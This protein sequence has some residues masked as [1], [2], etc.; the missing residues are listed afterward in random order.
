MMISEKFEIIRT[1]I[2]FG[3]VLA[4]TISWSVN[5]SIFWSIIHGFFGWLYIIYYAIGN[6]NDDSIDQ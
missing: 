4:V 5:R 3:T 2:G 6:P 1:G